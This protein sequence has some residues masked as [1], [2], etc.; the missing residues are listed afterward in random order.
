M[1]IE[2]R[3]LSE[4]AILP[5]FGTPASA[6]FDI[7]ACLPVGTKVTS[8]NGANQQIIRELTEPSLMFAPRERYLIPTGWAIKCP[9]GYALRLFSRSG[10]ALKNGIVLGNAVGVVD[11]DYRH[12]VFVMLINTSRVSVRLEHGMRIC[13]GEMYQP[14]TDVDFSFKTVDNDNWFTTERTG[15]FGSTGH[16]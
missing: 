4:H 6:C 14:F 9:T 10:F 8:Y 13:Q 5:T 1:N 11:E 16:K 3:Q 15:G 2:L 12:E 7:S